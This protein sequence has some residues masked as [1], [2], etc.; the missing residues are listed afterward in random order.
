MTAGLDVDSTETVVVEPA[1]QAVDVPV[2]IHLAGLSVHVRKVGIH[3]FR[4]R[5]RLAD[6]D[7]P[8]RPDDGDNRDRKDEVHERD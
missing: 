8:E 7:G 5:F 3:P 2:G 6:D 1:L 4:G